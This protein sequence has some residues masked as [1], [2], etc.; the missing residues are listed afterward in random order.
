MRTAPETGGLRPVPAAAAAFVEG[1]KDAAGSKALRFAA[2]CALLGCFLLLGLS[3]ARRASV[4]FDEF[5]HIPAGVAHWKARAFHLYAHN[6]PLARLIA[7]LPI[8]AEAELPPVAPAVRTDPEYRWEFAEDFMIRQL[9][10]RPGGEPDGSAYDRMVFRSRLPILLLGAALGVLIFIWSRDLFG[11]GGGLLSLGLYAFCPNMLA[12]ASLATTDLAA[13][14]FST[15][16]MFALHRY[17]K[18]GSPANLCLAG[19]AFGLAL[20]TKFTALVLFPLG[21]L[22]MALGRRKDGGGRSWPSKIGHVL[23]FSGLAWLVFCSGYFFAEMFTPVG[24]LSSFSGT[25]SGFK[26]TLPAWMP[27]PLPAAAVFGIDAELARSERNLGV[28]YLMGQLSREGWIS[29]FP[30]A[31]GAKVPIPVLVVWGASLALAAIRI[32]R[33]GDSAET[34]CLL[35]PPLVM[36]AFFIGMKS[37]NYGLR[38]L[39]PCFPF[40]FVLSGA[41]AGWARR[42]W[43]QAALLLLVCWHLAGC[44][45]TA[46]HFLAYFNEAAGGPQAGIHLLADS[47]LDWGQQLKALKQFMHEKGIEEIALSY[48]GPVDPKIYGIRWKP[49]R[50]G[51]TQGWAAVSANHLVGFFPMGGAFGGG[52]HDL[53][54]LRETRPEAIIANSLYIYRH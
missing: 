36:A 35:L 42:R 54:L 17:G 6:P 29:Y 45:R 3:S 34:V 41:V 27:L 10:R 38:Y 25:W 22:A 14:F 33:G 37:T 47:N 31:L 50:L 4:T 48:T 49:Y 7:V 20:L 24:E 43:M 5:A 15:L 19:A 26:N 21:A 18:D 13:A 40:L 32:G 9:S 30:T 52:V 28:F 2:V 53:S 8:L 39:L 1:F 11:I 44:L 23:V 51:Q 46:P 16:A 12:H